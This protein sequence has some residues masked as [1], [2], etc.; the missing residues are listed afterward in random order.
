MSE[1]TKSSEVPISRAIEADKD[2]IVN[3]SWQERVLSL[4][5][6][7]NRIK[8]VENWLEPNPVRDIQVF[9]DFANFY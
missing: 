8:I 6:D 7:N 5:I 2:K 1:I 9:L 4:R 3:G